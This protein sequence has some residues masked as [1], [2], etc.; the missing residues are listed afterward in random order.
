[1]SEVKEA[2][3]QFQDIQGKIEF[4]DD[5]TTQD[6]ER[7]S[8]REHFYEAVGTAEQFIENLNVT[9]STKR[10]TQK[11][12]EEYDELPNLILPAINLPIFDGSIDNWHFVKHI[13][14]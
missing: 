8:F 2:W 7:N 6:K 4:I 13:Q 12:D 11:R 3:D 14:I 5:S 1:M 10:T 9:T